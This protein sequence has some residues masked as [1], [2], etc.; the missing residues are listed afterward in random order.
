MDVVPRKRFHFFRKLR[1]SQINVAQLQ[2]IVC[3]S[4]SIA[5]VLITTSRPQGVRITRQ[6][7][8]VT[9]F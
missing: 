5:A 4:N 2:I 6:I 3:E 8:M 9:D 7:F 1:K